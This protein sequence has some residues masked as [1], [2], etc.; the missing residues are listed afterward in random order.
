[1]IIKLHNQKSHKINLYKGSDCAEEQ[2]ED[3][4]HAQYATL[5]NYAIQPS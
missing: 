2:T 1:M 4:G 5:M 3:I